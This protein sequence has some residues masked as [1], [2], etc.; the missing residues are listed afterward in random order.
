ML[1]PLDLV[2]H[3]VF[4]SFPRWLV[5]AFVFPIF[6]R[7]KIDIG[8]LFKIVLLALLFAAEAISVNADTEALVPEENV[9]D[10]GLAVDAGAV[11][12]FSF[13]IRSKSFWTCSI[14]CLNLTGFCLTLTIFIL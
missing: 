9:E 10:V 8:C 12:S 5:S 4:F 1:D 2:P 14:N 3:F 6:D 13:S 7:A 11:S